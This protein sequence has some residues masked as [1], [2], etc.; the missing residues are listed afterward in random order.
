[1]HRQVGMCESALHPINRDKNR[2]HTVLANECSRVKLQSIPNKE[3]SDYINANHIPG[4]LFGI[5]HSYIA[6]QAPI[7]ETFGDFWRMIWETDSPLILML[8][9]E[10]ESGRLKCHKYWP[11]LGQSQVLDQ[12]EVETIVQKQHNQDI[13][14]REFRLRQRQQQPLSPSAPFSSSGRAPCSSVSSSD[15]G[16][17]NRPRA[18]T[19]SSFADQ[20]SPTSP[21]HAFR[22]FYASSSSPFASAGAAP[23]PPPPPPSC[24]EE[25]N[26][27]MIQFLSWPD[28]G[29]PRDRASIHRFLET[30]DSFYEQSQQR[31]L[32]AVRRPPG[33]ITVHCSA[34]IGRTGTFIAIHVTLSLLKQHLSQ[35]QSDTMPLSPSYGKP[36]RFKFDIFNIV[37]KLK[38][39]RIGMVQQKEQFVFCYTMVLDE[40]ERLGLH[41]SDS[42]DDDDISGDLETT[43]LSSL[44][45][46]QLRELNYIS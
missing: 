9:N 11:D 7:P 12:I 16:V 13:V 44:S 31:R 22:G 33:P 34:G 4:S 3:G 24:V 45:S 25:K 15:C 1:M 29:V 21:F 27:V 36:E 6:T 41:W 23:P 37:R 26:V 39:Q 18:P 40:A 28:H 19:A 43:I 20:R 35:R 38:I 2:Y 46:R 10:Y 30:V 32:E 5:P 14:V 17:E 8:S 42:S